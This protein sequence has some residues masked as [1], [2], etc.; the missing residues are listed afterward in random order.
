MAKSIRK[1]PAKERKTEKVSVDFT[2]EE[3]K[4]PEVVEESEETNE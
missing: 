1:R 4:E 3:I 2:T